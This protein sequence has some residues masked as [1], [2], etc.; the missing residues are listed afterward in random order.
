M[1]TN[2][3]TITSLSDNKVEEIELIELATLFFLKELNKINPYKPIKCDIIISNLVVSESSGELLSGDMFKDTDADGNIQYV[4]SLADYIN[5][6]EL[7][8]T[9][10]HELIHVWQ[11]ATNRLQIINDIWH[12]NGTAFGNAPY[13][14]NDE[15][16]NLPWE[17]EADILDIILLKQFYSSYMN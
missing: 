15:D 4:C 1:Q 12:W 17:Q 10:A 8:R 16:F 2:D 14:G 13:V 7:M 6:I 5:S 11:S 3:I 9:L